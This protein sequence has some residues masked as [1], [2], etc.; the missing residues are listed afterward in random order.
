MKQRLD[1]L[2]FVDVN[3]HA[4]STLHFFRWDLRTKNQG[5]WKWNFTLGP[6]ISQQDQVGYSSDGATTNYVSVI[7]KVLKWLLNLRLH[8]EIVFFKNLEE[9]NILKYS[10]PQ[11]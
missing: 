2:S 9:A 10:V 8:L 1:F 5:D 11:S 3:L 4:Q 7:V 6:I